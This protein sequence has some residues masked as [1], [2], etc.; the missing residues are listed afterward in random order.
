MESFQYEG[1]FDPEG[2]SEYQFMDVQVYT[3]NAT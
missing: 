1:Q 3:P 2:V